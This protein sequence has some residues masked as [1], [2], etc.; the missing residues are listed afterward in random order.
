MTSRWPF[1]RAKLLNRSSCSRFW[2]NKLS[3]S[4]S[5][6]RL[7]C[8]AAANES[9]NLK[10]FA[11]LQRLSGR[12]ADVQPCGLDIARLP[13]SAS[14]LK[15]STYEPCG[16]SVALHYHAITTIMTNIGEGCG[17]A[18]S[19]LTI[20][21]VTFYESGRSDSNRRRPAWEHGMPIVKHCA[22]SIYGRFLSK[23]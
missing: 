6:D 16:F 2:N 8:N 23:K 20:C 17:H 21:G 13:H 15:E 18:K 4:H 19:C 3:K 7:F 5:A 12:A 9:V 10:F 11:T 1:A 14:H 22:T